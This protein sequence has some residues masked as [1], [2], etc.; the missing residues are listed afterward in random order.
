MPPMTDLAKS[1]EPSL[2]APGAAAK[3]KRRRRWLRWLLLVLALLIVFHRPLFHTV[4]RVVLI[5]LA[6]RQHLAVDVHFSGN[7]FTNLTV[8]G[9]RAQPL[10]QTPTPVQ[11][12]MIEEL[13]FDYNLLMLAKH[14]PG[15]FLRSYEIKNADLSFLALPSKN[16]NEQKEKKTIAEILNNILAQPAAYSDRVRVENFNIEVHTL[17]GVVALKGLDALLDPEKI[18]YLRAANIQIPNIPPMENLAAE[19]SYANRNFYL[20]E[21]KLAPEVVIKEANFDAS[22]RAQNKG[23]VTIKGEFF[24]GTTLLSLAG[25]QLKKKGENL[26]YGYDTTL[27][28]EA[29]S[30]SLERLALYL[31]K[32]KPPVATLASLAILFKGEPEKPQTWDGNASVRAETIATGKIAIDAV[33]AHST[34][35]GGHAEIT[36]ANA[37]AGKNSAILTGTAELPASVNELQRSKV[38]AAI[39]F[40][41]PEIASF[42]SAMPEPLQ[43]NGVGNAAI[44]MED[45]NLA[46]DLTFNLKGAGNSQM[47]AES[48]TLHFTGKT[49]LDFKA[50]PASANPPPAPAILTNLVAHLNVDANAL[51]F[52]TIQA[53]TA[54]IDLDT[55]GDL[56]TL[57]SFELERTGNTIS[58]NGTYRI[59]RDAKSAPDS[60]VEGEFHINAPQLDAFG[61]ALKE[62]MLSG[63]L[64]G[65]GSLKL[66]NNLLNGSARLEGS[67]LQIGEFKAGTLSLN[68]KVV[69]NQAEIDPLLLQLNATD[70]I[71]LGGKVSM[72]APFLYEGGA[73]VSIKNLAIFNPLLEAFGAHD[74]LKGSLQVDLNAKSEPSDEKAGT[75]AHTGDVKVALAKAGYGKIDLSEF[76]LAGIYGPAFAQSTEFR[77]VSNATSLTGTLALGE[78]KLKFRDIALMQGKLTVLSGFIFVPVDLS[79]LKAPIPLDQRIAANISA[80]ELDLE[81]L[82]VSFGK[83]SP[84]SGV[85]SANLLAS[86]TPLEP[87]GHLKVLGTKLKS[88]AAPTLDPA[89]FDLAL[90]YSK[91]ELTLDATLR[92]ALLQ[93]LT[94]KGHVPFDVAAT[95]QQKKIDPEL[96]VDLTVKLPPSSLAGASKLA[97]AVRRVDGTAAIDAH[98]GGTV[99]KPIMSGSANVK[100]ASARL[101]NEGAPAIGPFQANLAFAGDTLSF[102][103]FKGEVGGGTFNLGGVVHLTKLTE[104]VFEL[105]L[106]AK[107][108][109][110]KRDDSVTVRV[111]SDLKLDGPLNAALASGTLFITNSR[112]FRDID[113][114]PIGL[115]GRPKPKP[116]AAPS[117]KTLSFD[118]PPLRDWKFDIAIKTRR[119]DPFRIRGN[120]ANGSASADL[121]FA[122]T[123]LQPYLE[124]TVSVENFVASLP[125]SKLSVTRGFIYF[126]PESPFEPLLDLQAESRLR[127]YRI[128]A[129]VSGSARD[130]QVTLTS[131]PPLQQTDIV[132]LLATGATASELTDNPDVLAG[133]AAVLVFQQLYRKVFKK[134]EPTE[135]QLLTDRFDLDV[136]AVDNRTGRQEIAARFKLNEQLYLI[137]DIDVTGNF[138]G[139]LRYLLRFR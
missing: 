32:P 136:G 53:D 120:L 37:F 55:K 13:R 135:Q 12:I 84:V 78:G 125:F 79:N 57:R 33:E 39:T 41:L 30:I 52:K 74:P 131:E 11:R 107:D 108:I 96:P 113:I 7:I 22:Q 133:R 9:V 109:L 99:G 129:Y 2:P 66:V 18:G 61:F 138:T 15:E 29:S 51:R 47:G 80:K 122:G 4:A 38:K 67:K 19:T 14:G 65:E 35:K 119:D 64:T 130:P 72:K 103:T 50:N 82:L 139:R 28:I 3:P 63:A 115:P 1:P 124:G 98:L 69:D 93:P 92:Q 137:G 36:E 86:G 132:S 126:T 76:K 58:A 16:P 34:F 73:I 97:P 117:Q 112:F 71:A 123:G 46:G 90:H 100:I 114:L 104:P 10:D 26:A 20:R 49:V 85:F 95:V 60:P 91:K 48:A 106:Q 40:E 43:G 128:D 27:R 134:R 83:T 23:S 88:K 70:Q 21:L 68:A 77:V 81:Q 6:A 110:V 5:Q 111:D 89:Q 44:A 62:Q 17:T 105:K 45:G 121:K 59:P 31:N 8:R 25:T 87:S 56:V 127:D 102:K 118:K 116:K 101:A 54:K 42:T 24:G 75:L 94:I